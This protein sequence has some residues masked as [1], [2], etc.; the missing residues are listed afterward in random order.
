MSINKSALLAALQPKR[1]TVEIEGFGPVQARQLSV[2]EVGAIRASLKD[3]D[4]PEAFGLKLVIT[5][6]VDDSG[7]PIFDD[8]DLDQLS[9]A[10]HTAV[11]KMVQSALEINGFAKAAG[12]KN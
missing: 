5:S 8:A 6:F 9:S 2:S 10:S 4:V 3:G 1:S 12:A 11:E 7:A